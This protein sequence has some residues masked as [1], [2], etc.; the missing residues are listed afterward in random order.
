MRRA[1]PWALVAVALFAACA[2]SRGG[3]P[4]L[5]APAPDYAETVRQRLLE[6][7]DTRV[8]TLRFNPAA[9]GCPPFEVHLGEVWQRVAFDVSNEEDPVLVALREATAKQPRRGAG[10][11]WIVQGRMDSSLITCGRGALVVTM[12]P[13]AFGPPPRPDDEDTEPAP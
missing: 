1:L 8:F 7:N 2:S 4:S 10:H 12:R 11:T 13:I 6:A 9:C 3:K 5:T